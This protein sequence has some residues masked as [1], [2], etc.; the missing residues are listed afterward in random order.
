[1]KVVATVAG[2]MV[3]VVAADAFASEAPALAGDGCL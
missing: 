3:E 2:S 1:M